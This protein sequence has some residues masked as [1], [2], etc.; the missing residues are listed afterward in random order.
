M[1]V[2]EGY[3]RV[4]RRTL[5]ADE[6]IRRALDQIDAVRREI[7]RH[8]ADLAPAITAGGILAAGKSQKIAILMGVEGGH[9]IDSDL[10]CTK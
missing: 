10:W 6:S 3:N 9:M 1:I 4:R 5:H 2:D 8:P 7:A